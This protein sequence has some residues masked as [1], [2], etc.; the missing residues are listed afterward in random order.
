MARDRKELQDILEEALGS[1]H[2]YYQAPA[3]VTMEYPAIRYSRTK[4]QARRADNIVY[5]KNN[6]YEIVVI[7]RK[8]D[9]PVI[10]KILELPCC[11]H[12]RHYT[13]DNLHHDVFTLYF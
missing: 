6:R 10:D 11:E 7:D 9:S 2:V 1:K 5:L 13:A 12:D 3:N 8:P 4:I